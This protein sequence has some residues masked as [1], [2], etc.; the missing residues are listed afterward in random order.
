M[1]LI[2]TFNQA[3]DQTS[4]IVKGVKAD[5]M[6]AP[7]PCTEMD[8]KALLNHVTGALTAIGAGLRGGGEPDMSV[9]AQD[10]VGDDP[11]G[12]YDKAAAEAKA[13]AVPETLEQIV[14]MPFGPVPGSVAISVA[15]L[16]ALQHGWDLAR[17]TG[18][19]PDL[20]PALSEAGME[21]ARQFPAELVRQPG[22]Y[23]PEVECGADASA[24]DRLAAFLGRVV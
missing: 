11:A 22:V 4:G 14:N 18:Q 6:G 8:V 24:H 16:E 21:L 19:T 7:T 2:K 15:T 1:D 23:G 5:Q 20:D 3:V 17:A 12:A 9:F 13:A 10:L